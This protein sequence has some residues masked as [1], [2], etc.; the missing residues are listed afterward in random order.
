MALFDNISDEDI[1]FVDWLNGNPE[2]DSD[3]DYEEDFEDEDGDRMYMHDYESWKLD[4]EGRFRVQLSYHFPDTPR[5][6][7]VIVDGK[8]RKYGSDKPLRDLYE[9]LCSR[10][11]NGKYFIDEYF[12][13]FSYFS[14][15]NQLIKEYATDVL[16][17]AVAN[18]QEVM[19]H[20]ENEYSY[21]DRTKSGRLDRRKVY[22]RG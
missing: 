9:I 6:P 12:E 22:K 3:F 5:K 17:A 13:Q 21:Q 18:I 2:D 15:G 19:M 11:N 7:I 4:E 14:E 1:E 8:E 16:A 20:K 10:F